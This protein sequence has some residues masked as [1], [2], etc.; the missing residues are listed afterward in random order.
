V[1]QLSEIQPLAVLFHAASLATR[2]PARVNGGAGWL[3]MMV[4]FEQPIIMIILDTKW[5]RISTGLKRE[6]GLG[7]HNHGQPGNGVSHV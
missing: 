5:A 3:I 2:D 6:G 1:V 4:A 7:P